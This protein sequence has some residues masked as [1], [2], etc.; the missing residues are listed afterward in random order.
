MSPDDIFY[1]EYTRLPDAEVIA[2]IVTLA[3][4][5]DPVASRCFARLVVGF[6]EDCK[7]CK[8]GRAI[9]QTLLA[10]LNI[11]QNHARM[12]TV[13]RSCYDVRNSLD[14]WYV[15]RD[16]IRDILTQEEPERVDRIMRGLHGD[17]PHV[18]TEMDGLNAWQSIM[19]ECGKYA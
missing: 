18:R 6:I 19:K 13:L 4:S 14:Q 12:V 17:N 3:E 10:I 7:V 15:V 8:N 5:H 16:K 9:D 2:E 1:A 11:K